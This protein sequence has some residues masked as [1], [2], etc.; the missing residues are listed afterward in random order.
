MRTDTHGWKTF[1]RAAP[2]VTFHL[3]AMVGCANAQTTLSI[4]H[5]DGAESWP[6][7]SPGD[8]QLDNDKLGNLRVAYDGVFAT[9]NG[10]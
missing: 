8:L 7:Y 4:D 3:A 10:P 1:R 5:F 2:A 9:P 6:V